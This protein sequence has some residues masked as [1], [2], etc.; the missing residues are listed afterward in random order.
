MSAISVTLKPIPGF[1]IKSTAIQPGIYTL[2]SLGTVS[3]SLE[4][5]NTS[6]PVPAGLKIFI[7]IAWDQNVPPPPK[8]SEEAIKRAMEGETGDTATN[9]EY[10]VPVVVSEGRQDT[11]KA[12]KP[13]LVFDCVFHKS[14][15]TRTLVDHDFKVFIIELALQRVEAQTSL[16]LS[17][18]IGT[19][20]IAAKGKLEPRT[21]SL[22]SFLTQ[23]AATKAPKKPLI[24]EIPDTVLH[25]PKQITDP[26]LKP[27]SILKIQGTD[28]GTETPKRSPLE[29]SWTY[30]N[31]QLRISISVPH[32]DKHAI[33][34]ATFDIEP[35]RFILSVPNFPTLD[36]DLK[37][38]DAE[39]VKR[40]GGGATSGSIRNAS[41][42]QT[43]GDD[44]V[45]LSLKRQRP[46]K[47]QDATAEWHIENNSLIVVA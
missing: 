38:S 18:E 23:N 5:K 43:S 16:L 10:F 36:V 20:N 9:G 34:Q 46:F 47:V 29:W 39:I 7:N 4:A 19:P 26:T 14:V 2:A 21:V 28:N 13:S 35:R 22:P 25:K 15:K 27:K 41:D 40:L 45:T 1:C 24:E 6:I 37:L 3:N 44:N 32:L 33:S 30:E 8:A 11:D 12:G 17:R 31:E 42:S